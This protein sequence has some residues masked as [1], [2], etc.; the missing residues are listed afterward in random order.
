MAGRLFLV[1]HYGS[2][3]PRGGL[4]LANRVLP[5]GAVG[6]QHETQMK[7]RLDILCSSSSSGGDVSAGGTLW[8]CP[9]AGPPPQ[10]VLLKKVVVLPPPATGF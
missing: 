7:R 1:T 5:P 2:Q 3:D 8:Q 4:G 9:A 10:T 6:L